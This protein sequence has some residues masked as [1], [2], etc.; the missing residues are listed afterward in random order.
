MNIFWMQ[1]LVITEQPWKYNK[2]KTNKQ[3]KLYTLEGWILWYM[4]YISILKKIQLKYSLILKWGMKDKVSKTQWTI[5]RHWKW[6]R[7]IFLS[8]I[9]F[10]LK[11][12]KEEIRDNYKTILQTIHSILLTIEQFGDSSEAQK[13]SFCQTVSEFTTEYI[14]AGK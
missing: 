3:K 8:F 14:E 5:Q 9:R 10:P 2:N 7:E 1:M 13:L 12:E 6:L 11:L 4:Y